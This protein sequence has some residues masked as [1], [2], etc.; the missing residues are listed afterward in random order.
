MNRLILLDW[1]IFLHRAGYALKNQP[2]IS[3]TYL[4]LSMIISC[5]KLIK[6]TSKDEVLITCDSK[7]WR[8]EKDTTY[9][10]NRKEMREDSGLNWNKIYS[11]FNDFLY[12]LEIATAWKTVYV[13]RSEADDIMAVCCRHYPDK[14]I[15][16]ISYDKDLEQLWHYGDRIKIFSP[17]PKS[18]RFKVRPENFN[19]YEFMAEKIEQ[20]KSDNLLSEINTQDEYKTRESLVNLL[21]LPE[22]IESSIK[23]ELD[24]I[25][26]I[27]KIPDIEALPFPSLKERLIALDLV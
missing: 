11:I 15:I 4:A 25:S 13:D 20:E 17:H 16:I 22:E 27:E 23:L 26:K 18:K 6:Y 21:E 2:N 5:L 9:K 19:V 7:S 14:E 3:P 8:K 24:R 10:A 12:T 1:S